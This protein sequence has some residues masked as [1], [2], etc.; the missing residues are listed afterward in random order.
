ML[1]NLTN[2]DLITQILTDQNASIPELELA[3]RLRDA[4]DEINRMS[5]EIGTLSAQSEHFTEET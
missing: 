2:P 3:Y 4:I 5:E 1:D